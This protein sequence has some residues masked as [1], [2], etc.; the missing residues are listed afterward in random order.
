LRDLDPAALHRLR[1]Q[2]TVSVDGRP[3]LAE[4]IFAYDSPPRQITIGASSI[5]G[6]HAEPVFSGEILLVRRLPP[7]LPAPGH[8]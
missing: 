3:A 7:S 5:G 2:L 4:E 1:N 8:P 6:S